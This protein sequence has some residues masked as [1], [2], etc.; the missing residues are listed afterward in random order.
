MGIT[1]IG[2]KNEWLLRLGS[3]KNRELREVFFK[4]FKSSLTLISPFKILGFPGEIS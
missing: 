3:H 2:G 4:G 1:S